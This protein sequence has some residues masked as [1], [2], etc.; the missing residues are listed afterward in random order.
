[1]NNLKARTIVEV[2]DHSKQE[3]AI[4][5]GHHSEMEAIRRKVYRSSAVSDSEVVPSAARSRIAIKQHDPTVRRPGQETAQSSHRKTARIVGSRATDHS[6]TVAVSLVTK[7][8][9]RNKTVVEIIN[10]NIGE[11]WTQEVEP[12][13]NHQV[14]LI[15]GQKKAVDSMAQAIRRMFGRE[16][17]VALGWRQ[18]REGLYNA[19]N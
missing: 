19:A 3:V 4:V 15:I 18:C 11:I 9:L 6:A 12:G 13:A 10:S 7:A 8:P 5:G 16:A 1:M 14:A 2:R 17:A